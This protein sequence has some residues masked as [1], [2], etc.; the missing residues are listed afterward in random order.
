[1]VNSKFVRVFVIDL[2]AIF[3]MRFILIAVKL[4]SNIDFA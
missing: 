2:L 1:M 4:K 3:R